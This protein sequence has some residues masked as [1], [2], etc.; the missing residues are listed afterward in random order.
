[1]R[2]E[3]GSKENGK[4]ESDS[5]HIV[6]P[7]GRETDHFTPQTNTNGQVS[8]LNGTVHPDGGISYPTKQEITRKRTF[9]EIID[10]TEIPDKEIERHRPKPRRDDKSVLALLHRTIL[11][12]R[13]VPS[14]Q[15]RTEDL[16][17]PPTAE[18]P[19]KKAIGHLK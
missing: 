3:H 10:L 4:N 12:N 2:K 19:V 13:S 11:P 17:D 1:M 14:E 8:D 5:G 9:L 15:N 16:F 6:M 18:N 7:D